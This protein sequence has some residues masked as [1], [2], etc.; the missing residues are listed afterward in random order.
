MAKK[1][2]SETG[3]AAKIRAHNDANGWKTGMNAKGTATVS[4][5]LQLLKVLVVQ[6]NCAIGTVDKLG[7]MVD[8][9]RVGLLNADATIGDLWQW[10]EVSFELKA[11]CTDDDDNGGYYVQVW[12]VD[13]RI[14]ADT[15]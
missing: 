12:R 8:D 9:I 10:V 4:E 11:Y 5:L 13:R 7:E 1:Q 14:F 15:F 6:R 3:T 2:V